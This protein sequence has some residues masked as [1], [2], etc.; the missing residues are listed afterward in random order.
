MTPGIE[1]QSWSKKM[2]AAR[3]LRDEAVAQDVVE[4]LRRRRVALELADDGA[5]VDVVDA[6]RRIH[7]A[8]TR[9][10]TPWVFWRV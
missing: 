10:L 5:R 4:A 3:I 7:L 6:G 1:P 2:P 8:I 9:K